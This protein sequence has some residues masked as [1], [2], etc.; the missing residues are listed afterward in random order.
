MKKRREYTTEFKTEAV[1]L[2]ISSGKAYNQ[3]ARDLGIPDTSLH[4]WIK[5][6]GSKSNMPKIDMEE[7]KILR[8]ENNILREERDILK[9]ALAIFSTIK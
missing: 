2:A 4:T 9:K 7:V 3:T 1:K 6:A 5:E 8:K